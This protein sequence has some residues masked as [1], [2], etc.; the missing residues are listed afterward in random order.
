MDSLGDLL[1]ETL[2]IIVINLAL[3]GDNAAVIGLAI[4]DLPKEQRKIASVL[5][6]GVAI[7]LRVIFTVI[8]TVLIRIPYLNALGGLILVW[9]T[10][11]LVKQEDRADEE[12]SGKRS[13]MGAVWTILIADMSMSFDNVM[14]VAGAAEG[15]V[16]LVIFGLIVSIP[17][18]IYGSN[19]LADWMNRKPFLIYIGA[20]VL[21]HTSFA[22]VFHDKGLNLTGHFGG[23]WEIIIPYGMAGTVLVWGWFQAKKIVVARTIQESGNISRK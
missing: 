4:K 10:W 20:A 15:N 18:I 11:S 6:A 8:A 19:W 14:G 12:I 22:M 7:V 3:S 1:F 23:L 16:P 13:V 5:G 2:T 21:A 17:I 9:I